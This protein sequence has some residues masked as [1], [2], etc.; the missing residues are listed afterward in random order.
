MFS[1]IVECYEVRIII[2]TL[3]HLVICNEV[4]L[5]CKPQLENTCVVGLSIYIYDHVF[6]VCIVS[7]GFALVESRW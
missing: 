1:V 3:H 6:D 4:P 7:V 2:V 5:G